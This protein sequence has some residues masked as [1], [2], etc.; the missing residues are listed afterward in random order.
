MLWV[1]RRLNKNG[2][3]SCLLTYFSYHYPKQSI[4]LRILG[5]PGSFPR[6][7]QRSL[8]LCLLSVFCQLW[9]QA[10]SYFTIYL[11]WLLLF[12]CISNGSRTTQPCPRDAGPAVCRGGQM[13]VKKPSDTVRSQEQSRWTLEMEIFL[14]SNPWLQMKGCINDG[15]WPYLSQV[16]IFNFEQRQSWEFNGKIFWVIVYGKF[17]FRTDG[18]F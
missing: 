14:P 17:I 18:I 12:V 5:I 9:L 11:R 10:I 15:M 2:L 3:Q 6:K 1:I 4:S 13:E 7:R 16:K 8:P